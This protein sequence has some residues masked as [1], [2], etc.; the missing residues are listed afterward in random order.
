MLALLIIEFFERDLNKLKEELNLYPDEESIWKLQEGISNSTGNL[1]LHL[2]G[3]LLHFIGATLGKTGYIR[4]RDQEF[5]LRN[6]PRQLLLKQID[7]TIHVV[8][9]SLKY[10]SD[11]QM[12]LNFPLEKHGKTVTTAH[13]LLHLL[14]HLSYHLGQVNYHRRL[15]C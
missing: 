12:T 6:V 11:E 14:A 4:E 8:S 1:A 5:S 9:S 7:E 15:V 3:N 2:C 10:I 13:M